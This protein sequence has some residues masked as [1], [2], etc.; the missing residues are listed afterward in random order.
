M[1]H[2]RNTMA[3]VF[4]GSA[5]FD[6]LT[7]R[8]NVGYR[9]W[10]QG[11]LSEKTI[12]GRIAESVHFVGLDDI[13]E[14]MPGELAG[15]MQ[16]RVEIARALATHPRLILYDEPRAGLDPVNPTIVIGLIRR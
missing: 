10:D 16:K 2:V 5:L 9:L 4:Q 6:S 15:G 1:T 8:E 11:T 14:S 3:L 12:E 13:A 7:V